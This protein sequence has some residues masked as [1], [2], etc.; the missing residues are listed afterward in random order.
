MTNVQRAAAEL[1]DKRDELLAR[2]RQVAETRK[3]IAYAAVAESD[4]R[5]RK[6][7]C[8]G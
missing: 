4:P 5:V 2:A 6:R 1:T 8:Y 3:Q 7:V